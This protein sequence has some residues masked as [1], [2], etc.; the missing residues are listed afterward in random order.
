MAIKD[1]NKTIQK[2]VIDAESIY[3]LRSNTRSSG[4]ACEVIMQGLCKFESCTCHDKNAIGKESNEKPP[5]KIYF[6][7][8]NLRTLS[9]VST[10]L[11]I[12]YAKHN[13]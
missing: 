13:W 6:P 4:S 9:L 5:H 2:K 10:A 1:S 12:K 11:E 7:R 3:E 8:K